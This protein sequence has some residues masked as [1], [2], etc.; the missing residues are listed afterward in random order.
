MGYIYLDATPIDDSAPYMFGWDRM[1]LGSADARE[2]QITSTAGGLFEVFPIATAYGARKGTLA[3]HAVC[4]DQLNKRRL[5]SVIKGLLNGNRILHFAG[6]QLPIYLFG[7]KEVADDSR[8]TATMIG[9]EASFLAGQSL[10]SLNQPLKGVVAPVNIGTEWKLWAD[11]S[12]P[13]PLPAFNF[14]TAAIAFNN[15]GTAFAF[16][17]GTVAGGPAGDGVTPTIYLHNT[18]AGAPSSRLAIVLDASGN[19]SFVATSEFFL[20]PGLNT[21]VVENGA[22]APIAPG[23]TF[24][25]GFGDTYMRYF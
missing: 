4:A 11:G 24:T 6:K 5:E 18:T 14:T 23:A 8:K 13:A 16:A 20:A 7:A 3:I 17:A 19:G 21:L 1:D 9:V 2:P 22:G 25:I 15:W 10:W 12:L